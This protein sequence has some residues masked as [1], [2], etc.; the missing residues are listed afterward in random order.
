MRVYNWEVFSD[1][2]NRI[3]VQ[4]FNGFVHKEVCFG[5][6]NRLSARGKHAGEGV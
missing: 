6:V 2:E 5:G 4:L 1:F 3:A